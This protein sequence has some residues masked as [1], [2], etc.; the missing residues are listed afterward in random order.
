MQTLAILRPIEHEDK[1]F[2]LRVRNHPEIRKVCRRPDE[3]S[4]KSHRFW[5]QRFVSA[6]DTEAYIIGDYY[7]VLTL[8]NITPNKADIHINI[9]PKH[10]GMG[11]GSEALKEAFGIFERKF[12]AKVRKDNKR[13]IKFFKKAGAEVI[14]V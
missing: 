1:D 4:A 12:E 11:Y 7:G 10:Q 2:L 3:I 13:A 14:E 8:E 5:F 6:A 9:L